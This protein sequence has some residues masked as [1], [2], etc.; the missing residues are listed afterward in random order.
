MQSETLSNRHRETRDTLG[1][2]TRVWVLSVNRCGKTLN[3]AKEQVAVFLRGSLQVDDEMLDL[4]RHQVEGVAEVAELCAARYFDSFRKVARR[5][6][7]C[8][9]GEFAY[10]MREFVCEEH[11]D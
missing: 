3:G 9:A 6:T 4:V 11:S 10:R 8:T 7:V 5:N 1:V 2:T